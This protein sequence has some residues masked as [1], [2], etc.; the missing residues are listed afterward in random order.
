[1]QLPQRQVHLAT[2]SWRD[3]VVTPQAATQT[4]SLIVNA[5]CTA[6][7][8]R[9]GVWLRTPKAGAASSILAGGATADT[10]SSA[11]RRTGSR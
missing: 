7:N 2:V 9:T 4:E 3:P 5:A 8:N 10:N 6:C 1:M 11:F